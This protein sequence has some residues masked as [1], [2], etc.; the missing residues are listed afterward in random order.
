MNA[1][2]W[3]LVALGVLVTQVNLPVWQLLLGV[4]GLFAGIGVVGGFME[5]QVLDSVPYRVVGLLENDL[6]QALP[7]YVF[8]GLLLQRLTVAESI[9]KVFSVVFGGGG[10]ARMVAVFLLSALL[11]PLNGSVAA[12]A[13][14]L[15]RLVGPKLAHLPPPRS[16][17][18]VVAASTLGVVVPP[19]MVLLLL[20]DAIQRAHTEA[21]NWPGFVLSGRIIGTQD[22]L[23]AALLPSAALMLLWLLVGLLG[24]TA[25]GRDAP[26][27]MDKPSARDSV[28]AFATMASVLM[29]LVGV[30]V[31]WFR[32]VEAAAAAGMLMVAL[33]A[34]VG[35]LSRAQWQELLREAMAVSGSLFA[36]LVG[37]TTFSLV[38]RAYG[39]DV[40]LS[41]KLVHSSIG[42]GWTAAMAFVFV[43]LC[44]TLFDAFELIFVIVPLVAPA[45]I[46]ILNDA[47]LVAVLLLFVLQISFVLPPMGYAL[48][49]VRAQQPGRRVPTLHVMKALV[50][51]LVAQALVMLAMA[52]APQSLHG[53]DSAVGPSAQSPTTESVDQMI[54]DMSPPDSWQA[55]DPDKAAKPQ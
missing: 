10:R 54:Q 34:A 24:K 8:M 39:A 2:L 46:V 42:A 13:G 47:Q 3:M 43:G 41:D 23:N 50:P 51:Y 53:L 22:V 20:G 44:A 11:A 38:F 37:A 40:W 21:S 9:F 35:G 19:S 55:S 26:P 29:L 12:N 25:D 28:V 30:F 32:A 33:A 6:L 27:P 31:G 1:G 16:M 14:M 5:A 17:A 18:F 49:V 45:L 36:L 52:I 7:I 15:S 4:S 48:L